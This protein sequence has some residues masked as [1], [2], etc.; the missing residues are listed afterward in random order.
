VQEYGSSQSGG[1]LRW[2]INPADGHP[3]P[4]STQFFARQAANILEQS[5]PQVLG[6]K[7]AQPLACDPIINQWRPWNLQVGAN[8]GGQI[9]FTYPENEEW[10]LRMPYNEAYVQLNLE[11]PAV[12]ESIHLEGAQL[13]SARLAVSA[14]D[15]PASFESLAVFDLG[16]Q[17]GSSLS[18]SL[19]DYPFA[20]SVETLRIS[21]VFQ[22]EDRSLHLSFTG[23]AR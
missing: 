6:A 17:E 16:K 18:W 23:A 15:E 5:Y 22:G 4:V 19:Q 10:M 13:K 1:I 14:L 11:C 9:E 7:S 8:A 12:L 20:D 3:G 2:G 21:A